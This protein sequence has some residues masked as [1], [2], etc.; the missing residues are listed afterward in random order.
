SEILVTRQATVADHQYARSR[1]GRRLD[2][3]PFSPHLM[4]RKLDRLKRSSLKTRRGSKIDAQETSSARLR[5][6]LHRDRPRRISKDRHSAPARP[7]RNRYQASLLVQEMGEPLRSAA[8][9]ETVRTIQ[10]ADQPYQFTTKDTKF[11]KK[12]L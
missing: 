4:P 7:C 6:I 8:T 12:K 2:R 3:I 1:P 5:L 11:T 9:A 10:S